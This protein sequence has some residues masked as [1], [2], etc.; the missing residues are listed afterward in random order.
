[1]INAKYIKLR[2]PEEFDKR[3]REYVGNGLTHIQAYKMTERDFASAFG[4]GE[5][6]YKNYESFRKARDRRIKNGTMFH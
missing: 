4:E 3:F 2:K 6:K 5:R 1:M